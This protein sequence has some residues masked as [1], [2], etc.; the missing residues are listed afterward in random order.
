MVWISELS[1]R[2]KPS[3]SASRMAT[4]D[5][6]G[7]SRPSRSRL[8][9]T[10]TSNLPRRRSRMIS[11]ALHGFHVRVQVAH[12]HAVLVQV[13]GEVFRHALGE[14][15]DQ[16]ALVLR[17]AQLD[18]REHVVHLRRH[19]AALPPPGPPGASGRSNCSTV[20]AACA[21]FVLARRRR[22][23]N[24]LRRELLPLLELERPVVE[25]ARQAEAVFHQRLL[26]RAVALVHGAELRNGLV[27]SRR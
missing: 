14:R 5:T 24:H 2:R 23:E 21:R 15:G 22:H 16:H 10:S 1:L 25:R 6:S 26:A 7:M 17:R 12:L 4:S 27:R 13:L 8:M 3:L 20:C 18:L 19:R 9:P 11:D